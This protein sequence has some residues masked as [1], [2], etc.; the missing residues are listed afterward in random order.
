MPLSIIAGGFLGERRLKIYGIFLVLIIITGIFSVNYA[1]AQLKDVS[2]TSDEYDAFR[3][4]KTNLPSDAVV[5]ATPMEGHWI[6]YVSQRKNVVDGYLFSETGERLDDV[7][8]IYIEGNETLINKYNVSYVI[9][10][11]FSPARFNST[12]VFEKGG[13]SVAKV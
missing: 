11:R 1:L 8:K 3:W 7:Y 10:S 6:N 5:L 2:M 4:I 13:V 9:F 12:I